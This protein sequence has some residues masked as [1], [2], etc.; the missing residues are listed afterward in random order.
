MHF[1]AIREYPFTQSEICRRAGIKTCSAA[2]AKSEIMEEIIEKE[3]KP[4]GTEMDMLLDFAVLLGE[5]ILI[6]GGEFWRTEEMLR[7]IFRAY[8]IDDVQISM[9]PHLLLVSI[10]NA[11]APQLTRHKVIGDT[12]VNLEEL[13]R[14]NRLVHRVAA[15]KPEPEYLLEYLKE[16]T[17][18]QHYTFPQ[19]VGGMMLALLTLVYLFG[20][21][22]WEAVISIF[23]IVGVM[24]VQ[25]FV[26]GRL[27][28]PN[29][30][31]VNAAMTFAVGCFTIAAAAALPMD[32]YLVMIVVAFGLMPGVPL[33]NS[34]RELLCGR[35]VTGSFLL[36]QVMAE[37][38][39]IVAG[40]YVSI[41]LFMR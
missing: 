38:L 5:R 2:V 12:D 11:G 25:H 4:Q 19:V 29:K 7:C 21:G 33:I 1:C 24:L 14:L 26:N 6:R 15:R 22:V 3:L 35:I 28:E 39:S 37:T 27:T 31:V 10:R 20:G 32:A 23:S 36:L 18:G 9:Q 8:K 16:A 41:S 40:Y 34:F 13:T 17:Y 30:L